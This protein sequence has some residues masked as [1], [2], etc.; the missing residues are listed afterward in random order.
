MG[1]IKTLARGIMTNLLAW[2]EIETNPLFSESYIR[3]YRELERQAK[4]QV[5]KT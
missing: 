2:I 3:C 1:I 5:A 4:K